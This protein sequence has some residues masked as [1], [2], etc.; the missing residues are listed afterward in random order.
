MNSKLP[1]NQLLK[2][3]WQ[4]GKFVCIGLDSDF[5][6]LPQVIKENAS[7]SEAFFSFNKAIIDATND[8]VCAYKINSAFFEAHGVEGWK[9]LEKTCGYIKTAYPDIPL[10]L[11][12]K[13]AD[14]GN[15]NAKYA[16]AFFDNLK[17]DAITI[18]PYPG[19]DA[20]MPF[21]EHKDKGIIVWLGASNPGTDKFQD[22]KVSKLN[23]PLY[24]VIAR[25]IAD[26]WN[27]NGNCAVVMGA[28]YPEQIKDVR[29]IIG[30]MPILVPGIGAQ[31]GDLE[32]TLRV[33]LDSN[34]Q[35]LIISSSRSIIYASSGEDFAEAAGKEV[36]KLDNQIKEILK[37]V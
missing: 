34:N 28:T 29:E 33:G 6:K 24:Q 5:E 23:K 18:N 10:I 9:A 22:L 4:E 25:Q 30:D 32:K 11:D 7:K 37:D 8:L 3:K 15:T 1:F 13:R 17:A 16:Q 26:S 2:N 36:E 31:E 27:I 19:K 21:L 12:V 35:G 20:L 14:I